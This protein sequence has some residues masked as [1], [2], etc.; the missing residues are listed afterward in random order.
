VN[1]KLQPLAITVTLLAAFARLEGYEMIEIRKVITGFRGALGIGATILI[2]GTAFPVGAA[3]PSP[4]HPDSYLPLCAAAITKVQFTRHLLE[5]AHLTPNDP[6]ILQ[7][8]PPVRVMCG[9]FRGSHVGKITF[10]AIC[11]DAT[12]PA[13]ESIQSVDLDGVKISGRIP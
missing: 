7:K 6:G 5:G 2:C 9:V 11:S 8:G 13:C 1:T 3:E 4:A 12:T 10:D